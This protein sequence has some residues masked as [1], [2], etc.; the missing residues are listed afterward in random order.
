LG[1]KPS[2]P[3]QIDHAVL[4]LREMILKGSFP[5]GKRIAELKLIKHLN[6]SRTPL[7]L[8]LDRLCHEGLLEAR[9]KGGFLVREFS[10]SDIWDAIEIR[11]VMEGTAARLAAE[12]LKN[13]EDLDPLWVIYY[14][15]EELVPVN[16]ARFSRYLESNEVFHRELK[17]L[18]KSPMLIEALD[19]I[20]NWPFASPSALVFGRFESKES[21]KASEIAQEQHRAILEAI[22]NREGTRAEALAREHSRVS[23]GN[24]SRAL[25]DQQLKHSVPG[26]SLIK[27][28]D[29]A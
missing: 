26:S 11:G 16:M 8:A 12:R 4:T 28:P 2:K 25:A 15:L 20:L 21:P 3:S 7:R 1:P 29:P 5:P 10:I 18:S 27:W 22:E 9:M 6:V 17:Y 13:R 14:Q 23:R 19:H 24:L